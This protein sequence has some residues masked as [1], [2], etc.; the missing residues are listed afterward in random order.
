MPDDDHTGPRD[1]K[2]EGHI[3]PITGEHEGHRGPR[4]GEHEGHKG[5]RAGDVLSKSG[6]AW[7][8]WDALGDVRK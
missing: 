8:E 7:R 1:G 3:G 2:H 6:T 4:A 5:P